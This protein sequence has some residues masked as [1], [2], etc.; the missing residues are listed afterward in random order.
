M[1]TTF[2]NGTLVVVTEVT[3]DMVEKGFA[4]LVARDEKGNEVY[5]VSVGNTPSIGAFGLTGNTY[6]DGKLAVVIVEPMGSELA[7]VQRKYGDNLLVAKKATE[8]I[9]ASVTSAQ[10]QIVALFE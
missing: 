5:R 1:K 4:P 7:D 8:Q 6:V 10:E 9:V 2:E 3:K